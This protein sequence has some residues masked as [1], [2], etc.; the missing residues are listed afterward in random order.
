MT[1]IHAFA[2]RV[3]VDLVVGLPADRAGALADHVVATIDEQVF[4]PVADFLGRA[5]TLADAWIA[6]P[7]PT[8]CFMQIGLEVGVDGCSWT[9]LT[10][11]HVW[12]MEG[13]FI[14]LAQLARDGLGATTSTF[15]WDESSLV[16]ERDDPWLRMQDARWEQ[17]GADFTWSPVA[18]P[19]GPFYEAVRAVGETLL[20]LKGEV[21]AICTARGMTPERRLEL[22]PGSFDR[23]ALP[24]DPES[25]LAVVRQQFE[26]C[27]IE[28]SLPAL[29]SRTR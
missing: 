2:E 19:W 6:M 25:R 27:S 21:L 14:A 15:V 11:D 12:H 22:L 18:V 3:T 1:S 7:A 10:L 8:C 16:L 23:P 26:L 17:L 13:W 9:G 20:A 28:S 29:P 4:L 24:D 5:A